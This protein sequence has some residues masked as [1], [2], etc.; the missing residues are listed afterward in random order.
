MVV[1][2]APGAAKLLK[3]TKK[4][5]SEQKLDYFVNNLRNSPKQQQT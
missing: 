4:K 5:D 2:A 1:A 3:K